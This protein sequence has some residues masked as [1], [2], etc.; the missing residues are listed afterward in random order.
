M[1]I[2]IVMDNVVK[3]GVIVIG[4]VIASQDSCANS[5]GGGVPTT[6]RQVYTL[7]KPYAC[8]KISS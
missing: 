8:L 4:I 5:I 2:V 3:G 7:P 6:A 1:K